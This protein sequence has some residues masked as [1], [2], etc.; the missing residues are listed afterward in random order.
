MSM[1]HTARGTGRIVETETVRGRTSHRVV[2]TGFDAWFP[3]TGVHTA[4]IEDGWQPIPEDE[5]PGNPYGDAGPSDV[6]IADD[7]AGLGMDPG[8]DQGFDGS[9]T[10]ALQG[11]TEF[12]QTGEV[13]PDAM[14]EFGGSPDEQ[15]I[16]GHRQAASDFAGAEASG[17]L[18]MGDVQFPTLDQNGD[19]YIGPQGVPPMGTKVQGNRYYLGGPGDNVDDS[20]SVKLPY[21]PD[22]QH[23]A[24][25]AP[26]PDASWG[27]GEYDID[28]DERLHPA[29]S[30]TFNDAENS[31]A[32]P[33]P[34]PAPHLFA[35]REA[36]IA[37]YLFGDEGGDPYEVLNDEDWLAAHDDERLVDR[38][39]AE[40]LERERR[41][42][43]HGQQGLDR[44]AAY[45]QAPVLGSKYV[46]PLLYTAADHF[47]DPVQMF[48][49]DP[50]AFI[51]RRGSSYSEDNGELDRLSALIDS[52]NL[53]RQG[54]WRD[55]RQ[56][57]SR[58]RNEGKVTVKDI[59][60]DRI[61]ATVQGDTGTYE[62]L[63]TKGSSLGGYDAHNSYGDQHVGNWHC[64]CK[65]GNWAF[66]RRFTFIGRLC[67]HGLACYHEMQSIHAK[68]D[69]RDPRRNRVKTRR[70]E[71]IPPDRD[72]HGL[73]FLIDHYG[74]HDKV[75]RE[76]DF[77]RRTDEAQDYANRTDLPGDAD[78]V[79]AGWWPDEKGL[80]AA[81]RRD[82][83]RA[84]QADFLRTQ[85]RGM[86]PSLNHI[87]RERD[88]HF[89]SVTS[90][91]DI[92]MPDATDEGTL[93]DDAASVD[94]REAALH[95]GRRIVGWIADEV[96]PDFEQWYAQNNG[97]TLDQA[98]PTEAS[99]AAGDYAAERGLDQATTEMLQ[100]FINQQFGP[101]DLH[102]DDGGPDED[103]EIKHFA[104]AAGRYL[105][106]ATRHL[107]APTDP[108][109]PR[110]VSDYQKSIQQPANPSTL[111]DVLGPALNTP[112]TSGPMPLP[113]A[114]GMDR[115]SLAPGAAGA[116]QVSELAAPG[117]GSAGI[118]FAGAGGI[119]APK[120]PAGINRTSLPSGGGAAAPAAPS[121][122]VGGGG[123][124]GMGPSAAPTSSPD[125]ALTNTSSPLGGG[126][127]PAAGGGADPIGAGSY[128]V[129]QGDTLSD[130]AQR[131]GYGG[132]YNSLA[133]QNSI[134]DPNHIETGQSIN[135][136]TPGGGDAATSTPTGSDASSP[137][138]GAPA[139]GPA[140]T[141]L[142]IEGGTTDNPGD[143]VGGSVETPTAP[144]TSDT[145]EKK[146]SRFSHI[147]A[148]DDSL[149]NH[150]RSLAQEPQAG[151][152]TGSQAHAQ[153]IRKTV[154]ELRDRGYDASQLVA[155]VRTADD[156]P[157]APN[158]YDWED[159]PA[160]PKNKGV[161]AGPEKP[162]TP[163]NPAPLPTTPGAAPASPSAAPLSNPAPTT[164][165]APAAS[166]GGAG[167][168]LTAQPDASK[169]PTPSTDKALAGGTPQPGGSQTNQVKKEEPDEASVQGGGTGGMGA[170]FMQALPGIMEGV[171]GALGGGLSGLS[172]LG[173]SL[174]GLGDIGG[175]A[176]GL[177]DMFSG[178]LGANFA[179]GDDE[180]PLLGVEPVDVS[181]APTESFAGSGP[182]QQ[183]WMSSSEDYVAEHETD[184]RE[185]VTGDEGDITK[186][187]AVSDNQYLAALMGPGPRQA[188]AFDNYG[189]WAYAESGG[190]A[191]PEDWGSVETFIGEAED[192]A[193]APQNLEPARQTIEDHLNYTA[194]LGRQYEQMYRMGAGGS[195]A[196]Y[197]GVGAEP[198][199]PTAD[200]LSHTPG[201][202]NLKSVT[203]PKKV[204]AP[205]PP[206]LQPPQLP[207]P[208][209][210]AQPVPMAQP[211]QPMQQAPAQQSNGLNALGKP[212]RTT[213]GIN[214]Q[215]EQL[216]AGVITPVFGE[217]GSAVGFDPGPQMPQQ[218]FAA[219]QQ[220][221]GA[222][223]PMSADQRLGGFGWDP[224]PG[225]DGTPNEVVANQG[226]PDTFGSKR[227]AAHMSTMEPQFVAHSQ[228]AA[229]AMG[230][231]R[232][233]NVSNYERTND[234]SEI[235]RQ[236]QAQM[237]G[238]DWATGYTAT[239]PGDP[240][241]AAGANMFLSRTAGRNFSLAD[242]ARLEQE[243]HVLGARNLDELDLSGTHYL[244]G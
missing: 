204:R 140:L 8:L 169:N 208:Q 219:Q 172:D 76:Q 224:L 59:S 87:P 11:L 123:G 79:P 54:S 230:E 175:M 242:Q 104:M 80:I 240:D 122:P 150:L 89:E 159:D 186:Y 119:G 112:S 138:S 194:A 45:G 92:D 20:N 6:P 148:S 151:E 13:G 105:M 144:E 69:G 43:E 75:D 166:S 157:M 213:G 55:V 239:G 14:A 149:L 49:D 53:I 83:Q 206:N 85:P 60:P 15:S 47:N 183:H 160:N 32:G 189:D 156:D 129:Q 16:L 25:N 114:G 86:T 46:T 225:Q 170:D 107:A 176:S 152:Q 24:V 132:D 96:L 231:Y 35:G 4:G 28:A 237:G 26:A 34:G 229:S 67:S 82:F 81:S 238:G 125:V 27:P 190:S 188:N 17:D 124:W 39:E 127:A 146:S 232:T 50:T 198:R 203:K 36:G 201:A 106:A 139:T 216:Q 136:G 202:P 57:A 95:L 33:F 103:T 214:R 177:G 155:M 115:G 196:G 134:A 18:Q 212:K 121:A 117:G 58:L 153:D 108:N 171:G 226:P 23:D 228:Q 111:P 220:Q 200:G 78:D 235:V 236:F 63:I 62:T 197:F 66:K 68:A 158:N 64:S 21:N 142:G 165:N 137:A 187:S 163:G 168:M 128:T 244:G 222:P 182:D 102:N 40:Q 2:G 145:T 93:P 90:L 51:E 243:S 205:H 118:D 72:D 133:Q 100:E 185:S 52:D 192:R 71:L 223:P 10:D 97:R 101:E 91:E 42:H 167:G 141:D 191:N 154:D 199:L 110:A 73:R 48:R 210:S 29:D 65:W 161:A 31:E 135:I 174:G 131:S 9:F 218:V 41:F 22:P 94:E 5:F 113:N 109:D 126:S 173:G 61:Y 178:I 77:A 84:I 147:L 195:P 98:R 30:L 1:V 7:G 193:K 162:A 211:R 215:G 12:S 234:S 44:A 221:Y 217:M 209:V 116:P 56:K 37:E 241:I 233:P 143:L 38:D 184:F 99:Q 181:K 120:G 19:V 207:Q 3:Q 179:S 88:Q 164:P 180:A 130:I 74:P 227:F 70:A